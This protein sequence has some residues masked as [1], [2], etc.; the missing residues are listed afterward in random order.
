MSQARTSP[1]IKVGL[2]QINNSFSGQNYFP[3]SAGVLE[4]HARAHLKNPGNYEFLIPIFTRIN[5]HEA[6]KLIGEADV[7]GF[8]AYVWNI[9]LSLKIAALIKSRKPEAVIVFGGP[10]VPDHAQDFLR[11]H[12]FI[13]IVCHGEGEPIFTAILEQLPRRE[14]ENIPSVSYFKDGIF[15]THP[16]AER[17]KNLEE[18]PSPYLT[19]VFKPLMRANPEQVWIAMWETNRGCPFSCTFCDWGSAVAA[20]VNRWEL[21]R[22]YREVDWF[23]K[24]GIEFVFCADANFGI[25]PRD[26]D[27]DRKSVV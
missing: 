16:R 6:V 17:L 20:K 21:D 7:I 13:D 3:Y 5:P 1:A 25:L 27:L 22:L 24:Q 4:A 11:R 23:V 19:G 2:V 9:N 8:S 14:W 15:I 18:I 26:V 10:H 12:P